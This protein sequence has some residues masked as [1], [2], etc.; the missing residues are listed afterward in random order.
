MSQTRRDLD[1]RRDLQPELTPSPSERPGSFREALSGPELSLLA[2]LKP[3][4]PSRGPLRDDVGDAFPAYRERADAVSVLVD[5]PFFGGGYGLFARARQALPLPLLAKGFFVDPWQVDEARSHGADA[6]LL[7]ARILDDAQLTHL[8]SRIEGLGMDAL[9]E[10]HT[11][12]ELER[13][14]ATG[15]R[16]IGVNARDLDSLDIDLDKARRRLERVPEGRVRVAE[17]GLERLEDVDRI[18]G[19]AHAALIGTAF[20]SAKDIG[21]AIEAL[22]W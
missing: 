20:M 13:A 21:A 11:D 19:I 18:R 5:T 12:D 7:I 15:A 2:E 14:L 1:L 17:S 3:R 6:V 16:V 8:R 4:S 10:V 22:G 9:V